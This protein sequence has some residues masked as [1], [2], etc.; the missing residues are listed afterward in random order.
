[1]ATYDDFMCGTAWLEEDE[2]ELNHRRVPECGGVIYT[3]ESSCPPLPPPAPSYGYRPSMADYERALKHFT[4]FPDQPGSLSHL[5]TMAIVGLRAGSLRPHD[6]LCHVRPAAVAVAVLAERDVAGAGRL[7]ANRIRAEGGDDPSRWA[8]LIDLVEVSDRSLF[9]L[10]TATDDDDRPSLSPLRAKAWTGHLW[11]PA[12]ILLALAPP[13]CARRYFVD[14]PGQTAFRRAASAERMAGGMPLTRTLVDHVLSPEGTRPARANLAANAFT[15]D[16]V[17]ADLM[18]RDSEPKIGSAVR[19]HD[20]A[21]GAVRHK[22]FTAVRDH[23]ALLRRSLERLLENGQQQF[24]DLLAAVPED[25]AVWLHT[26]VKLAGD[27]LERGTRRA[28]YLRL[29]TVSGPEVVWS[30][31]LALAG[32]LKGMLPEVRESMAQNSVAPL[33]EAA[34]TKPFRDRHAAVNA[35]AAQM[36][37]DDV[38]EQPLPWLG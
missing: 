38:L 30:V 19:V 1:M 2:A 23:P 9:A 37:R 11:R 22:A 12:N 29:A 33:A 13:E 5:R 31:D 17:L 14:G 20:F 25:D 4:A 26:L 27:D 3:R 18:R 15:P 21:A 6:V 36:R 28:A 7:I 8:S 34:W 35:A 10:L 24:L 32:S 16:V